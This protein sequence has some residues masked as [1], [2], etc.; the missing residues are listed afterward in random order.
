VRAVPAL[1]LVVCLAA[2]NGST[3]TVQTRP[4]RTSPP[5]LAEQV[6]ALTAPD[7]IVRAFAACE[8]G[9]MRHDAAPALTALV[10]LLSDAASIDPVFCGHDEFG[11]I[12]M[13]ASRKSA[14]GL[15]AAR[16]LSLIGGEGVDALLAAARGG[17][18]SSRRH[19]VHG[20]TYVRDARAAA[21]F[22]AAIDDADPQVRRDA[23][24]GLGRF[25]DN[26]A[27][28]ALVRRLADPDAR[29]REAAARSLGRAAR[30]R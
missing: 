9:E 26:A 20:L 8:L 14:P 18:A 4:P 23:A 22:M 15:E 5:T 29:V 10:R 27:V 21:V 1:T 12:T 7:P 2:A 13:L 19:A 28:D 17:D 25:R 24:V 16:A 3:Q 11:S 30:N 6:T